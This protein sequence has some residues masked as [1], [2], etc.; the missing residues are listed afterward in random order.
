MRC[1]SMIGEYHS[2]V[3]RL[4]THVVGSAGG[5]G[6]AVRLWVSHVSLVVPACGT[7]PI[8]ALAVPAYGKSM[9]IA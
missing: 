7:L 6:K 3:T 4:P 5:F 8:R 2:L 9:Y 1:M